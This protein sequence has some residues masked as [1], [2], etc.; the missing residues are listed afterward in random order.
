MAALSEDQAAALLGLVLRMYARQIAILKLA[1]TLSGI[2]ELEIDEAV[3]QAIQRLRQFPLVEEALSRKDL[4]QLPALVQS[5][6]S[7][8]VDQW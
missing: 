6:E 3:D 2:S 8:P 5:L 1:R 4:S 7:V